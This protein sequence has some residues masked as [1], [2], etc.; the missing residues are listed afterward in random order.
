ME[1]KIWIK[2]N[3]IPVSE[4]IYRTY[5]KG[6]RKER[7][8]AESDTHNKVFSYDALDTSEMNGCDIFGDSN[9]LPVEDQVIRSIDEENLLCALKKL[10]T[11]ERKLIQRIYIYNESLRTIARQM[12]L[13]VTTLQYRHKKILL[14]LKNYLLKHGGMNYE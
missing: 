8:F 11:H 6:A 10:E 12:E 4:E 13:P 1:Y 3:P 7:Y 5:W 14:K 2:G 9:A